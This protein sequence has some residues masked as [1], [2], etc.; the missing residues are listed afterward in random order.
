MSWWEW[1]LV[2]VGA[3]AY[4]VLDSIPRRCPECGSRG[5]ICSDFCTRAS[6]GGR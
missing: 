2:I 6:R 4:T 3:V 5:A 1:M